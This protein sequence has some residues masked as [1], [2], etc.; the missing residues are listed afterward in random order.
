MPISLWFYLIYFAG[1]FCDM[2]DV[3]DILIKYEFNPGF[4]IRSCR[5]NHSVKKKSR[6]RA[7]TSFL[8][9]Q[10]NGG[11][12]YIL[13]LTVIKF[14]WAIFHL[15]RSRIA[16]GNGWRRGAQRL[17]QI[18]WK[19]DGGSHK[20]KSA[21]DMDNIAICRANCLT[22][23]SFFMSFFAKSMHAITVIP[24]CD[25]ALVW[26]IDFRLLLNEQR[27]CGVQFF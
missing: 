11:V 24:R 23:G 8:Q 4:I 7:V 25:N 22:I 18:P 10:I 9:E 13:L 3:Y 15:V 1:I 27:Q 21:D 12:R 26:R 17:R 2:D 16:K 20:D 6:E 14:P 5:I 19:G